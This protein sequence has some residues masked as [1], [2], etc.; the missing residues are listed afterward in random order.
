MQI[1]WRE[2]PAVA[3]E[4]V[5]GWGEGVL[6]RKHLGL[7]RRE[8]ALA[9]I[10]GRARRDHVLPGGLAAFAARDDVVEGEVF[11]RA[12]ILAG[13]TIAQEDVESGEGGMGGRFDE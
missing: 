7:N 6:A 2:Q 1:V 11:G 8:V 9:Q 10:A 12:A 4:L 5:H 3:V 13:E